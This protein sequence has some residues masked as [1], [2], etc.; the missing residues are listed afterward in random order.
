MSKAF[1]AVD[2]Q[3]T[4]SQGLN[5]HLLHELRLGRCW[6]VWPLLPICWLSLRRQ[7]K[8]HNVCGAMRALKTSSQPAKVLIAKVFIA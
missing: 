3:I 2:T 7:L 6:I 4:S 1:G 5:L 8:L